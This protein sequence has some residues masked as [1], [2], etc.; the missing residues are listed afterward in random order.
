M[1]HCGTAKRTPRQKPNLP[2]CKTLKNSQRAFPDQPSVPKGTEW[3][4]PAFIR[5]WDACGNDLM[6][7]LSRRYA[8]KG[9]ALT[10]YGME[11]DINN[12]LGAGFVAHLTKPVHIQALEKVLAIPML[13]ST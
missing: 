1:N 6:M 11:E 5:L 13:T 12:S 7:E 8:L 9:I 10:G 2:K 3:F 4:Y